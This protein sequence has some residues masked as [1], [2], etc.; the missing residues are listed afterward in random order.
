MLAETKLIIPPLIAVGVVVGNIVDTLPDGLRIALDLAALAILFAGFLI[1]GRLRAQV[2]ATEGA[3][4][5]WKEERDAMAAK[6][7]RLAEEA[8]TRLKE[9]GEAKVQI[10]TLEAR[11]TLESLEEEV[12]KLATLV[13]S[14]GTVMTPQP[15]QQEE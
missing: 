6:A 14:A 9:L 10:A 5:A 7:E 13:Q 15:T 3:A 12:R 2:A 11:P 8:A 4:S 1:L